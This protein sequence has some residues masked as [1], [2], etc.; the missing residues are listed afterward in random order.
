MLIK[1]L[2]RYAIYIENI[3]IYDIDSGADIGYSFYENNSIST[4]ASVTVTNVLNSV[5]NG[6]GTSSL[7]LDWH[8]DEVRDFD[9]LNMEALDHYFNVDYTG[10][11]HRIIMSKNWG[12]SEWYKYGNL[13]YPPC[14]PE[15]QSRFNFEEE[16]LDNMQTNGSGL[17]P[18]L[19]A[20]YYPWGAL[21]LYT[22]TAPWTQLGLDFA[23][24][25]YDY[26]NPQ[27]PEV[28]KYSRGLAYMYHIK[29][30]Y[31]IDPII[32]IMCTGDDLH[33]QIGN[34]A[35][36]YVQAYLAMAFGARGIAYYNYDFVSYQ[37]VIGIFDWDG[38]DF[39]PTVLDVAYGEN[40]NQTFRPY[41]A[42]MNINREINIYKYYLDQLIISEDNGLRAGCFDYDESSIP[43]IYSA[44]YLG[45]CPPTNLG[46]IRD[47]T[48]SGGDG[49]IEVVELTPIENAQIPL[50][51]Y[52]W[53]INR[54]TENEQTIDFVTNYLHSGVEK[55]LF[56]VID[57]LGYFDH[58]A[59][60][61]YYDYSTEI[62][63]GKGKLFRISDA[64]TPITSIL[65]LG[66][67]FEVMSGQTLTIAA[68]CTVRVFNDTT[69]AGVKIGGIVLNDSTSALRINGTAN[70]P[71]VFIRDY[72]TKAEEAADEPWTGIQFDGSA[73]QL[74]NLDSSWI[75]YA[76]FINCDFGIKVDSAKAG[77]AL[78][79]TGCQ[80]I[81]C[82]TGVYAYKADV[83]ISKSSFS[84]LNK[85]YNSYGILAERSDVAA[86]SVK[87]SGCVKSVNFIGTSSA[88]KDTLIL[89]DCS[90]YG[91]PT[92]SGYGIKAM[93]AVL[94]IDSFYDTVTVANVYKG[95][96]CDTVDAS[97]VNCSFNTLGSSSP[98]SSLGIWAKRS[99]FDIDTL[100][101]NC[102]GSENI[103]FAIK[104]FS[105]GLELKVSEIS[106]DANGLFI[107]IP[108]DTLIKVHRC[109][110][111]GNHQLTGITAKGSD[112]G[113]IE[114]LGRKS[115]S[116]Y[117]VH[118][119]KNGVYINATKVTIDGDNGNST[120]CK[121]IGN[122]QYGAQILSCVSGSS[123]TNTDY[124][125][126]GDANGGILCGGLYLNNSSPTI[127]KCYFESNIGPAIAADNGSSASIGVSASGSSGNL[128]DDN[129]ELSASTSAVIFEMGSSYSLIDARYNNLYRSYNQSSYL[130]YFI[131]NTTQSDA[132][133][134]AIKNNYWGSSTAPDSS[135]FIP[136]KN[137]AWNWAPICSTACSIGGG[138]GRGLLSGGGGGGSGGGKGFSGAEPGAL[139]SIIALETS[140][141][142]EEAV[143]AYQEYIEVVENSFEKQ[144]A[145]QRVLS[146][147]IGGNFPLSS[148]LDYY[149]S[150]IESDP[151]SQIV[152]T[153][154]SLKTQVKV[155]IGEYASAISDYENIILNNPTLEDSVYAVIN[156]GAAYLVMEQNSVTIQSAMPGLKPE[157]Q[158]DF[159]E[160]KW[161]LLTLLYFN[162]AGILGNGDG[163]TQLLP[164]E[165]KLHQNYPNPF[166]PETV[167]S[168]DLPELSEVK[169]E[170]FNISGQKVITLIDGFE[171][172]GYKSVVWNGTS[173]NEKSVAS[174]MYIYRITVKNNSGSTR[175][176]KSH[177]ML[178]IR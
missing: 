93:N 19:E 79:I 78:E 8:R 47:V 135:K 45:N 80:F 10:E 166:N 48:S 53:L 41:D 96:I 124:N 61:T 2:C 137:A 33:R 75:R 15:S 162:N 106:S 178:L 100:E 14:M 85:T 157:S 115:N 158:I 176:V 108:A 111:E 155:H 99:F 129:E 5:Y 104:M 92:S 154:S 105:C 169:L 39:I 59:N 34:S 128:F 98:D 51:D 76:K 171:S 42:I 35:E 173:D 130:S 63:S 152:K 170:I 95:M 81:D 143:N 122:T 174:G 142:F 107:D 149:Q 37:N 24:G 83:D 127:S 28:S 46:I 113:E 97:L 131:K 32:T 27:F 136:S 22:Y 21:N 57:D 66:S 123:I 52:F 114:I 121:L 161:S 64:N 112:G 36:I 70:N 12:D 116:S 25:S 65:A 118:N 4:G 117:T 156:A 138:G 82:D 101:M 54:D 172:P 18:V 139:D 147:S 16:I 133:N 11:N 23:I 148:L 146:A 50:G 30:D 177:K 164:K 140:G 44:N 94:A 7:F 62:G 60:A 77:T 134:R 167:I 43:G 89:A 110:F 151:D 145:L 6:I 87:I 125:G 56:E 68:G 103:D 90:I 144:I 74:L 150:F 119:F 31:N 40:N 26:D 102:A 153:A 3:C 109:Y 160:T 13:S 91:H 132:A 29:K 20:F 165:F 163:M 88:S 159:E 120:L 71:V 9:N 1:E 84:K 73:S 55:E 69:A 168:Y 126:N 67:Q 58:G 86:D 49:Y 38:D 72:H 17:P 175:F 141:Q